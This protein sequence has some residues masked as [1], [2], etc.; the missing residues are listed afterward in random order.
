MQLDTKAVFDGWVS[1]VN[2]RN[3]AVSGPI[4]LLEQIRSEVE[5]TVRKLRLRINFQQEIITLSKEVRNLKWLGYRVPLTIINKAHQANQLYPFAVSLT[6]SVNTYGAVC[7]RVD[8]RPQLK[9]LLAERRNE[10]IRLVHEGAELVW[11]SYKLESYT[12]RF[13][14]HVFTYQEKV[15]DLICLDDTISREVKQ[16]ADCPFEANQF[17]QILEKVQKSVDEMAHHSYSNL[18][19]WV[20][21]L[22]QIIEQILANRLEEAIN[23]WSD[24]LEGNTKWSYLFYHFSNVLVLSQENS[25]NKNDE[26]GF[27]AGVA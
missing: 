7:S 16:L 13:Q 27:L 24:K 20:S 9:T 26:E 4:F 25:Q 18:T 21:S 17:K 5:D 22:D 8:Q 23:A 2:Q 19:I 3:F 1:R 15:D 14:D 10:L 11:D 6:E 12:Q